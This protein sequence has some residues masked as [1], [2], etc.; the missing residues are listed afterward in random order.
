MGMTNTISGEIISLFL[1]H[2]QVSSDHHAQNNDHCLELELNKFLVLSQPQLYPVSI[3]PSF[4]WCFNPDWLVQIK[5]LPL[6]V[7]PILAQVCCKFHFYMP[8]LTGLYQ[9][10]VCSGFPLQKQLCR[11]L[12]CC[13]VGC[14]SIAEQD[15][16]HLVLN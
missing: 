10:E 14:V 2:H 4:P 11:S 5:N 9:G 13:G 8:L 6:W 12:I 16:S 7:K 1:R 15:I 3:S